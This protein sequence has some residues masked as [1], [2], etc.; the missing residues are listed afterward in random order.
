MGDLLALMM[1]WYRLA[2]WN[3]EKQQVGVLKF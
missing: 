2:A 3:R 1:V